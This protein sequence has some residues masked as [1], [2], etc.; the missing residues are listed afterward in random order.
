ML[1]SPK[2]TADLC[3]CCAAWSCH[4]CLDIR[5]T[6]GQHLLVSNVSLLIVATASLALMRDFAQR[7]SQIVRSLHVPDPAVA[8]QNHRREMHAT[9]RAKRAEQTT[10]Q[11]WRA[12]ARFFSGP[13]QRIWCQRHLE[14]L[15]YSD[16]L[17]TWVATSIAIDVIALAFLIPTSFEVF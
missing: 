1:D 4:P 6:S 3:I 14:L 7:K 11:H 9:G 12:R 15:R 5:K 10:P 8:S 2:H 13:T 16:P 17:F